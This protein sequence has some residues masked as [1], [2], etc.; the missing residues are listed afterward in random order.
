M[1]QQVLSTIGYSFY[2]SH[3]AIMLD[4]ETEGKYFEFDVKYFRNYGK[5]PCCDK[6]TQIQN[7]GATVVSIVKDGNT[8][9][10]IS[11]CSNKD[12]F[13]KLTGKTIAINRII[14]ERHLVIP[15]LCNKFNDMDYMLIL[16]S[17]PQIISWTDSGNGFNLSNRTCFA[18]DH[19]NEF[20]YMFSHIITIND[21]QL[22]AYI[23]ESLYGEW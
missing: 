4:E 2:L 18:T 15:H 6:S 8:H 21:S 23:F 3:N 16:S 11:L 14:N 22:A 5:C 9:I 17:Y 7:G 10:G 1:K 19:A 13:C 12:K 20:P